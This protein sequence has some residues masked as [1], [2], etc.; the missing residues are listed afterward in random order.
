MGPYAGV[1]NNLSLWPHSRVDSQHIY[2]G[3]PRARVDLNPLSGLWIWPQS[4]LCDTLSPQNIDFFVEDY[5]LIKVDWLVACIAL[6][7]VG[8]VLVVFL[9]ALT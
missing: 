6:R 4:L 9:R 5:A 3:Q 7:V 2:H 8:A 1:D